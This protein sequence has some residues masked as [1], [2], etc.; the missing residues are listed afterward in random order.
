MCAE[1]HGDLEPLAAL[2]SALAPTMAV[3]GPGAGC[4]GG[5]GACLPVSPEGV[6]GL[7]V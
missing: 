5:R 6:D 1:G 7:H 4:H 2:P 3:S